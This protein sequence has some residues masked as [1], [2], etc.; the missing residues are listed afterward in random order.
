MPPPSPARLP[1]RSIPPPPREYPRPDY[2]ERF[3][4][5]GSACEDTCCAGWGVPIDRATYEKYRSVDGLKPHLGTLIVLNADRPTTSDYARIP[6]TAGGACSFL[7][8][9]RMCGIEKQHG[10]EMLS[11]TCAT[12]PRAV[13]SNAGRVEKALNLSCPEA[14]RLTLLDANLLGESYAPW[15]APGAERYAAVRDAASLP[16]TWR[17]PRPC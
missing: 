5:I 11:S 6:L 9:E 14:A 3:R 8:A 10:P 4:C 15:R 13:S 7:D 12:Y 1:G 17:S 2:A 16:P